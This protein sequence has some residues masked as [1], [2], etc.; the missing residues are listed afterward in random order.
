[1]RDQ[2]R[3]ARRSPSALPGSLGQSAAQAL[4]SDPTLSQLLAG[5]RQAQAWFDIV[6][7][8][9]GPLASQVRAGPI[10]AST[11]TLLA[12]HGSAAA[13]L[14]QL[15]PELLDRLKLHGALIQDLKVK[16]LPAQDR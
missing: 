14:R 5:H 15:G 7:P 13:K 11:W 3:S 6:R 16:V 2:R 12:S 4:L 1:M 8:L 10:D 9:L